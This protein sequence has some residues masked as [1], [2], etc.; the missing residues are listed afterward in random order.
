MAEIGLHGLSAGDREDFAGD[1]A[2][3]LRRQEHVGRCYFGG[4]TDAAERGLLPRSGP[5]LGHGGGDQGSQEKDSSKEDALLEVTRLEKP[6][7][8]QQWQQEP[9]KDQAGG[10]ACFL[11]SNR[12]LTC[13]AMSDG[14]ASN[15]RRH[16][17]GV[18][19]EVGRIDRD[20]PLKIE[21]RLV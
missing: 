18:R 10:D 6:P 17:L 21:V 9:G 2:G 20:A 4:W 11:P 5:V 16:T 19:V 3:L 12:N 8:D 15:T 14:H 13:W 7:L 1:V